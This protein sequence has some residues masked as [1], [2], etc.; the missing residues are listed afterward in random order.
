MN[1]WVPLDSANAN[2]YA[3]AADNPINEGWLVNLSNI[4][5]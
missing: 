4:R 2:L 1:S 3:A 5:R